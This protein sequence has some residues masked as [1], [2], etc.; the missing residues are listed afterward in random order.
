MADL[1]FIVLAAAMLIASC[2]TAPQPQRPLTTGERVI[3]ALETHYIQP[4]DIAPEERT[5]L[6][7][8]EAPA[9]LDALGLAD[10]AYIDPEALSERASAARAGT[11]HLPVVL[12]HEAGQVRV[13]DV[14]PAPDFARRGDYIEPALQHGWTVTAIDGVA[15]SSPIPDRVI[16]RQTRGADGPPV[17]FTVVDADGQTREVAVAPERRLV[18]GATSTRIGD[19]L[20]IRVFALDESA[21]M[22]ARRALEQAEPWLAGVV[23][24][25]RANQG[26]P[27]DVAVE[28]AALFL[29]RGPVMA[30][31]T[32]DGRREFTQAKRGDLARGEPVRVLVDAGTATGGSLVA[33]ALQDR[34]RGMVLGM[35]TDT[36]GDFRTVV[37]LAGLR[38]GALAIP[39]GVIVRPSGEVMDGAGVLPDV[40]ISIDQ[41]LPE[42]VPGG[43]TVLTGAMRTAGE[44]VQLAWALR[45]LEGR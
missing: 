1:R 24:D 34:R 3:E 5:R 8:L 6:A 25:L 39:A 32:R 37:Q 38:D 29:D 17:A 9:I 40:E 42:H 15:V 7:G 19:V 36:R 26:G 21:V 35:P 10:V 44:D 11:Y 30:E 22:H 12:T 45:L 27:L 23:V 14:L 2:A 13:L 31:Q 28:F 4:L 43:E 41:P 20:L 33:A 16:G 18:G